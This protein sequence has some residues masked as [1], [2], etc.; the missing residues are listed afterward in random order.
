MICTRSHSANVPA[1]KEKIVDNQRLPNL[2]IACHQRSIVKRKPSTSSIT[3]LSRTSSRTL[4][5]TSSTAS[6]AASWNSSSRSSE[7]L[8]P[9]PEPETS[10]MQQS[11]FLAA[12][13][14]C[15]LQNLQLQKKM[16]EAEAEV[17]KI[18]LLQGPLIEEMISVVRTGKG[19]KR[20]RKS[21]MNE[22][23]LTTT[24]TEPM[25]EGKNCSPSTKRSK[26]SST[27]KDNK[28]GSE[29][30]FLVERIQFWIAIAI[31]TLAVEYEEL[32][33]YGSWLSRFLRNLL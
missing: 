27:G 26:R 23:I 22:T 11:E 13:G 10:P 9:S 25:A 2:A 4:S 21:S 28:R 30:T 20:V 17:I 16:M 7:S 31:Y 3:K 24:C 6:S 29:S 32:E 15:T 33:E 12:L 8:N 19:Q 18:G 5:S 14:L 1:L